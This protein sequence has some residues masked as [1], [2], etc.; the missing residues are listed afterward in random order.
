MGRVVGRREVAQQPAGG[1][2]TS[3]PASDKL[4]GRRTELSRFGRF[5]LVGLSGTVLDFVL[6]ILLKRAGLPTLLANSLS[7][8]AGAVS[9][10]TWNRL[11]TFPEARSRHWTL[12][13]VQ[14][15]TVSL[16]GLALNDAVVLMLQG[17]LGRLSGHP[18]QGYLL[19]KVVATGVAVLWNYAGNRLWTFGEVGRIGSAGQEVQGDVA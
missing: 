12:Q 14:F 18:A 5:L 19:A 2:S 17:S 15:F 9:N 4:R 10:F 11:W 6:L 8:T 13:L 7:F 16:V 1:T 3:T